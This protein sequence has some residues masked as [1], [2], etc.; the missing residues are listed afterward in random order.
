MI[1][2]G[3][4]LDPRYRDH[5]VPPDHPERP[6]RIDALI[7]LMTEYDR[8]ALVQIK[9]RPATSDDLERNHDRWYIDKVRSAAKEGPYA[10]D[11][12]THASPLSFDTA[13]LAA[14]GLLE[15]CDR[16][17]AG[18]VQNGF[19]FVRPPGHHAESNRAMGFCFFNNVAVA[20]R[21]LIA[22]YGLERVLIVDWDVHHGNGT[23]NSFYE[24]RNVLYVSAHQYPHYPGSGVLDEVGAGEGLGFTVNLPFPAGYGDQEYVQAFNRIVEPIGR[25]FDPDFVLISAG[26]DCHRTDPLSQ[27]L[28][29]TNGVA[30][31][32]RSLLRIARDHCDGKCTAVLEGGYNLAALTESVACV[33]DEMGGEHLDDDVEDDGEITGAAVSAVHSIQRQFWDLS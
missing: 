33:L 20:A 18:D 3:Y 17:M 7:D 16:V 12:D 8:E 5:H 2:T 10:F 13:C 6:E 29:T 27:A 23:Q 11:L 26:F 4:V 19:A 9:P 22:K 31:M 32:T 1:K 28:V 21:Y 15:L 24:D 30:A 25:Q 14:G